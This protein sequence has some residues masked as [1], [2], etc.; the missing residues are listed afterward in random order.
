MNENN[1]YKNK[2]NYR[3]NNNTSRQNFRD[4]MYMPAPRWMINNQMY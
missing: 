3:V 2:I 4:T 1:K